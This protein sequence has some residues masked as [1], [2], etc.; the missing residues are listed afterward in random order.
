MT[1]FI[2]DVIY[3]RI[4]SQTKTYKT[5]QMRRFKGVFSAVAAAV[6]EIIKDAH[7]TLLQNKKKI[8]IKNYDK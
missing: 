4:L 2:I 7:F 6:V 5:Q 3:E 1:E 8:I